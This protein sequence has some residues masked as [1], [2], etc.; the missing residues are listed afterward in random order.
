MMTLI[1]VGSGLA[2]LGIAGLLYS[3]KLAMQARH[4]A[5]P[6]AGL[7]QALFWNMAGFFIAATGL[8]VVVVAIIL[9]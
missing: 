2:L 3:A 6:G 1:W 8:M 9:R 7:Q 5:E 4:L